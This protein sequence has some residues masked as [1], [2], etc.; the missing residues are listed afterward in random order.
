M[1]LLIFKTALRTFATTAWTAQANAPN[2]IKVTFLGEHEPGSS[3]QR[4]Y[5]GMSM[6]EFLAKRSD[7]IIDL[8]R[9][10]QENG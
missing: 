1:T 7:G 3:E 2:E 10:P 9:S 8:R 5:F 4:V 6:G